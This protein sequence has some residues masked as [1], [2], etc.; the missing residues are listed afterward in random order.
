M[1]SLASIENIPLSSYVEFDEKY[2]KL[3][4]SS[5]SSFENIPLSSYVELD[6]RYRKLCVS[7]LSSIEN[8]PLRITLCILHYTHI[9][10]MSNKIMEYFLSFTDASKY[11]IKRNLD[12]KRIFF[13]RLNL[14]V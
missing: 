14:N 6:E 13:S 8:I 11:I 7:S 4:V 1:Y 5:L 12:L 9:L 3:C 2:R 10:H